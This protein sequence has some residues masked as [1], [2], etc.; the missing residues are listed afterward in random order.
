MV[1]AF[2]T[3]KEVKEM[4]ADKRYWNEKME[5]LPAEEYAKVQERVLLREL[6]YVW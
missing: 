2:V 3:H 6:G 1:P 4:V 5:T